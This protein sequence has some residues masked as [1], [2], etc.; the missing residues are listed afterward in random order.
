M[1]SLYHH[2]ILGMKWGIR[3]FQRK[4]GSLTPT[5]RQRYGQNIKEHDDY[6]NAH[7]GKSVKQ[8]SDKEL[9]DKLNRLQMERQYNQ[10]SGQDISNGQAYVNK[11]IKAGTTV[12]SVT[13]TALTIYNN[14]DKIAKII[15]D[16][17]TSK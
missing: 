16:H 12:A 7:S 6:K 13:T 5:G 15:K 2:G 9:R 14:S 8:M 17:F 11:L 3:R 4:D 10:L 1:N